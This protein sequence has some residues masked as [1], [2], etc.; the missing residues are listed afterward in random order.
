MSRLPRLHSTESNGQGAPSYESQLWGSLRVYIHI[1]DDDS[2]LSIFSLCRPALL[3]EDETDDTHVLRGGRWDRERWW[4]TFAHVCRRWRHLVL[5][6]A[7][8]LGLC[9][10]C[11]YGTPVADMLAQS[12]A[13]PLVMDYINIQ[14]ELTAQD[15]EGMLLAL[16]HRDRVRRIRLWMPVANLEKLIA[17][18]DDEF[19]MLDYLYI[20]PPAK[21]DTPLVLPETLQAPHLR[22]L[23][24]DDFA[25]PIGAPLLNT[26]A[27][28]VT[29]SLMNIH[30]FAHF[31]PNDML[32]WLSLLPQLETLL[33][34]FH[35]PIPNRDV[36]DQLLH[37][38]TVTHA[39]LPNLRWFGFFGTSVYLEAL[40]PWI[41]TPNLK[42]LDILLFNQ[43]TFSIPHLLQFMRTTENLTFNRATIGFFNEGVDVRVYPG[44]GA[45]V[46]SLYMRII[47]KG[48]DWQVASAAQIFNGPTT[49]FSAVD[50]LAL[51]YR[52][53][54]VPW[55]WKN[56]ADREQWR[57]L[58]RSFNRVKTLRVDRK[59][60]REVS[61]SLQIEAGQSPMEL[62]PELKKL[63]YT[64]IDDARTSFA[65]FIDARQTAGYPVSLVRLC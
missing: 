14:C 42:R 16:R 13:L 58:L 18:M 34:A 39:T 12:P 29:L 47:C 9:L 26:A 51:E 28:I 62:L 10:L 17:A 11:T 61:R 36:E 19:P 3:D 32:Q 57:E 22:H 21:H 25:F 33:I 37:T 65:S 44:E 41:T 52:R 20:M 43:L 4:Y 55:E 53:H 56:E 7:S 63:T 50:D 6:S 54:S 59:L 60:I 23:I 1:L 40:L 46:F 45:R 48:L 31:P 15:E 27:A 35:S 24:L 8:H 2:L 30:P 5:G 49:V 64:G 38:P